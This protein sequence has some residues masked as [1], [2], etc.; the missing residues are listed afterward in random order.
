M[1]SSVSSFEVTRIFLG[2]SS[3]YLFS[4]WI[5]NGLN[6]DKS[7]YLVYDSKFEIIEGEDYQIIKTYIIPPDEVIFI[8]VTDCDIVELPCGNSTQIMYFEGFP[9][10]KRSADYDVRLLSSLYPDNE[11]VIVLM[12]NVSNLGST[13]ITDEKAVL[14]IA[15]Q[16]YLQTGYCNTVIFIKSEADLF[17]VFNAHIEIK[18]GLFQ[19][20]K[21]YLDEF[22]LCISNAEIE[23]NEKVIVGFWEAN[24]NNVDFSNGLYFINEICSFENIKSFIGLRISIWDIYVM[25]AEKRFFN[26]LEHGVIEQII[27]FYDNL[28]RENQLVIWNL[29][30]DKQN[31]R[32]ELKRQ[33]VKYFYD[34]NDVLLYRNKKII[35]KKQSDYLLA[36]AS[37]DKNTLN[38]N[39]GINAVFRKFIDHFVCK[40]CFETLICRIK[41]HYLKLEESVSV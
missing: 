22:K 40:I 19:N 8:P 18:Y 2:D 30:K 39:F 20:I 25:Q 32:K 17:K 4:R 11:L 34:N 21:R 12:V 35:I 1:V 28:I 27:D 31:L 23:F 24:C 29:E 13:D 10:R 33:F 15:S 14:Q 9:Y 3:K 7:V 41:K 37:N 38:I 5:C 6:K 16:E 36:I 26:K